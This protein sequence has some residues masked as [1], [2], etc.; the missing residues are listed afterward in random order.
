MV[1]F[2]KKLRYF[3]YPTIFF[4]LFLIMP[5]IGFAQETVT[6]TTYYPSPQGSYLDLN[7]QGT[8]LVGTGVPAS[9]VV[10]PRIEFSHNTASNR[11]HWN[12]DQ[13]GGANAAN[14]VLRFFT[15]SNDN[16][17]ETERLLIDNNSLVFNDSTGTQHLSVDRDSIIFTGR[18][19]TGDL[20]LR[21]PSTDSLDAGDIRF[22]SSTGN[23][24]GRIWT[25]DGALDRVYLSSGNNVPNII[26]GELGNVAIGPLS[27]APNALYALNVGGILEA[28]TFG[29]LLWVEIQ[30]VIVATILATITVGFVI[31][32]LASSSIRFK[33]NVKPL[34]GALDKILK[35]RGVEFDWKEDGRHDVGMIAEE[36]GRAF[37]EL[38]TYEKDGKTIRG[39]RYDGLIGVLVEAIKE[40]NKLINKQ[41][42]ELGN[43]RSRVDRLEKSLSVAR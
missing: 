6:I 15:E 9:P 7:V 27:P 37:P 12:I 28:V 23:Q 2:L 19:N 34:N 11:F 41:A 29:P 20:I 42:E 14:P 33:K 38:L 24:R 40:Q 26:I 5:D 13:E 30:S 3:S 10:S 31:A 17:T 25:D 35:L 8:L 21:A 22:Q 4:F 39:F 36:V 18:D 1:Y 32:L 16:T 43:L